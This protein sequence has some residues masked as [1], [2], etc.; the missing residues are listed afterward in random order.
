[1]NPLYVE[2]DLNANVD[3]DSSMKFL[4]FMD[5]LILCILNMIHLQTPMTIHVKLK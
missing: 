2:Y 1:M 5:V 4:K 3:D